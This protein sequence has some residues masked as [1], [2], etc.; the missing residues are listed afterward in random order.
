MFIGPE[1]TIL[2]VNTAFETMTGYRSDE[3]I[4]LPCT[5]L[6]CDACEKTLHGEGK[7]GWC[8]LFADGYKDIKKR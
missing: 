1:G 3:A 6:G 2:M 7:D 4:G 8:Q 5:I